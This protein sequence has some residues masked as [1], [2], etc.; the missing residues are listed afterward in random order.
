MLTFDALWTL[1]DTWETHRWLRPL[2]GRFAR[3]LAELDPQAAPELLLAAAL[4]SHQLGRGHPCLDLSTLAAGAALDH[5]LGLPPEGDSSP[6]PS[7]PPLWPWPAAESPLLAVVGRDDATRRESPLVRDGERL[8]LRRY[9]QYEQDVA[10]ALHQ[11]AQPEHATLPVLPVLPDWLQQGQAD[12]QSADWQQ[13]ACALALRGRLTLITGGP[14]TGKTTTVV[15]LLALLQ[16]QAL[17]AGQPALRIR[18]AA[19]TGKAA[20]RLSE[21]LGGACQRLAG[22]VSPEV[23]A[24]IPPSVSTVHRLLGSRP[25]SRRFR[26]H[27]DA[28]LHADVVV[29]DEASMI[30]LE[31][32]AAVLDALPE[33]ARLILL[34][35]KDQLASVEAGAVL[36]QLCANAE[37]GGYS[38]AA[39]AWLNAA[40]RQQHDLS[41][42]A[43]DPARPAPPLADCTVM[44][45]HSHRFD[46][47]SGIGQLAQAVRD[48]QPDQLKQVWQRH[49]D[50]ERLALSGEHDAQLAS[51]VLAGYRPVLSAVQHA[52]AASASDDDWHS[53]AA[54]CLQRFARFQLLTALR[55]GPWGVEGLNQRVSTVLADAG[56][57]DPRRDWYVGRPVILTRNDHALGLMNGDIGLTVADRQG[58]LQVIFAQAGQVRWISP[59]RLPDVD[60]VFAM[61]VHKS[62]GSEFDHA[63]LI[64]PDHPGPLLTRELVYTAITRAKTRFTLLEA[65]V[66]LL[67][68]AAQTVTRRESGLGASLLALANRVPG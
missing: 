10:L 8:Y 31:M 51:F 66:G 37:Q 65:Q 11:R 54:G 64:L 39:L 40:D 62:Q 1:L 38:P 27:R 29:I 63:A 48:N 4:A 46:Q 50:I 9:W 24:S 15:R 32:M 68:L 52:L 30:D 3:F 12:G 6:A 36:G 58:Q 67:E 56:L 14:G 34:G 61:T 21:S 22:V 23:L 42:F 20:A 33:P 44:L 59:L 13:L 2:D 17:A 57:I 45:R 26:H 60:T 53:W 25:D 49:Q 28:P 7:L 19:P 5:V 55:R 16:S 35:D 18:L 43:A 41:R 47:H